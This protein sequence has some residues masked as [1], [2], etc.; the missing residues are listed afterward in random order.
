MNEITPFKFDFNGNAVRI[1]MDENG[2]PLFNAN[3]VCAALDFGNPWQAIAS[4]VDSDD[5]HKLEVIDSMGRTQQVNHINEPGVFS[6]ILGSHKPEAKLFK[7]WVLVDVLPSIRKTGKYEMQSSIKTV[8]A[9]KAQEAAM[10]RE[11][12]A[13]RTEARR[14]DMDFFKLSVQTLRPSETSKIKMLSVLVEKHGGTPEFLPAYTDEK[15]TKSLTD[16]LKDHGVALSARA[17]N[18]TLDELGL[19]ETMYRTGKDKDGNPIQKPYKSLTKAGEKYGINVKSPENPLETQ[20]HY[21]VRMF[22]ELLEMI[23]TAIRGEAA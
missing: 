4:H 7:R 1:V 13:L 9:V 5:L 6:L 21:Y 8:R 15:A 14:A 20:P 22:P 3:D 16:L 19:L 11:A 2:E 17:T 23:N 10:L 18:P 12:R